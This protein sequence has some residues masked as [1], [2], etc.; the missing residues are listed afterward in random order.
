MKR[1]T[2]LVPSIFSKFLLLIFFSKTIIFR[3]GRKTP[4][5]INNQNQEQMKITNSS[6]D[7]DCK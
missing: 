4:K 1:G 7:G 2:E 6:L 5:I 3:I